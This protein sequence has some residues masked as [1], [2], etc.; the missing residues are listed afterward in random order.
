MNIF[1]NARQPICFE[2]QPENLEAELKQDNE[3]MADQSIFSLNKRKALNSGI[4]KA[5][6]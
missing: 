6:Q 4:H 2:D 5:L 1:L 3:R